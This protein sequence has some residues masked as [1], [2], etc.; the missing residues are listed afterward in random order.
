MK[1][2]HEMFPLLPLSVLGPHAQWKVQIVFGPGWKCVHM[3]SAL[4]KLKLTGS[5]RSFP[6]RKVI[7]H[8]MIT[9]K[10]LNAEN[11]SLLPLHSVHLLFGTEQVVFIKAFMLN[12]SL[13]WLETMLMRA[14][15]WI[16]TVTWQKTMSWKLLKGWELWQTA[17]SGDSSL[18]VCHYKQSLSHSNLIHCIYK[19]HQL[20][21]VSK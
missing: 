10:H 7:I 11:T 4:S 14:V 1:N 16:K 3:K 21:T 18:W 15:N 2:V 8:Q 5:G 6:L 9:Y 13:F 20:Q 17:E 19:K 12:R